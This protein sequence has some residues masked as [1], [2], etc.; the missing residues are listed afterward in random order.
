MNIRSD[1]PG[2]NIKVLGIDEDKKVIKLEQD[3]RNCGQ[4]WFYWNFC[5]ESPTKGEFVFKFCNGDVVGP[6]GPAVSYNRKDWNWAGVNFRLSPSSFRY[7]FNGHEREVY[8]CFSFP[9]QLED[10]ERFYSKYGQLS[11]IERKA[12]TVSERGRQVPLIIV[13]KQNAKRHIFITCRHHACESVASY[14]LEGFLDSIINNIENDTF[15]NYQ[16]HVVPFV[17]IDGVEEGEQGKGRLPHDHNRD[18]INESIYNS[19]SSLMKYAIEKKPKIFIDLHCPWKWGDNDD[20]S[21]QRNNNVFFTKRMSPIK[22]EVEKLGECLKRITLNDH[23]SHR[24]IYKG[25]YDIS[26]GE[27][28]FRPETPCA[29]S[30]FEKIGARISVT[31]EYTYFGTENMIITQANL[32]VFGRNFAMVLEKKII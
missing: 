19:I 5:V 21:S 31:C 27:D 2:G 10:F 28:W 8:F 23:D 7:T 32:R 16:F 6:W 3:L 1:Y 13:G 24:V 14:V 12:L 15:K 29:T 18:Y 20:I 11:Y 9:Y 17:D 26:I 22:E 30:F 4:W 25:I